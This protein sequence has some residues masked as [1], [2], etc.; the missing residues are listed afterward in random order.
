MPLAWPGS[1]PT[2]PLYGGSE[3]GQSRLLHHESDAGPGKLRSR[4]SEGLSMIQ[5][6]M[7]L[8]DSQADDL[9]T[10]YNVTTGGGAM[11]FDFIHPRTLASIVVRFRP[12]APPLLSN[13]T[14]EKQRVTLQLEIVPG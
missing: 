7:I 5:F 6:P 8:T 4:Y 2:V 10:F 3:T 11:T 1:L 14:F 12:G 13:F 9:M